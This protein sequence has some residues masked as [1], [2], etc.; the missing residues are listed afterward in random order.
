MLVPC[1]DCAESGKCDMEAEKSRVALLAWVHGGLT[2]CGLRT[3]KTWRG[4]EGV[5]A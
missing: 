5:A 2:V 4:V 3:E 1:R